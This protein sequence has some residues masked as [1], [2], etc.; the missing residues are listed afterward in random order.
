MMLKCRKS[1]L[2][3]VILIISI[4][5]GVGFEV[6]FSSR[7]VRANAP[8][9]PNEQLDE[10]QNIGEALAKAV[11]AKDIDLILRYDKPD[12]VEAD[13]RLLSDTKSHLYCFL[14]DSSCGGGRAVY[15]AFRNADQLAIKVVDLGKEG[16]D[17]WYAM[18]IFFDS[19]S[20]DERKLSSPFPDI[21]CEKGGKEIFTWTFKRLKG[22]W[23]SAHP[24]FDAETDVY[25]Y[26]D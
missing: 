14:F 19:S 20:I 13:R 25:C 7:N 2:L 9:I 5:T 4:T 10:L 17:H 1:S 12:L 6:F 21:L 16:F 22:K 23:V 3:W 8:Q 18:I 24:P 11:L 15:D 26:V